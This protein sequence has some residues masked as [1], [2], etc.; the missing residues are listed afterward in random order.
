MKLKNINLGIHYPYPIHTMKAYRSFKRD[1]S[2]SLIETEN[3]SKM[4]FSLP[5]Y[6][7]IKNTEIENIVQNINKILSKI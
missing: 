3:S 7:S 6:P 5:I 2:N 1:N 4:I